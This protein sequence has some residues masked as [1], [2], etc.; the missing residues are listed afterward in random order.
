MNES[1]PLRLKFAE[2]ELDETDARL[3]RHGK[4]IALAPKAFAV[5]CTLARR[6][7]RLVTK[8]ALIDAVW[9]HQFISESVLKT[10]ISEL[11]AALTDD[12][13]APRFIETASRR[14]YRFIADAEPIPPARPHA[15]RTPTLSVGPVP[16]GPTAR[17]T[18]ASSTDA[19]RSSPDVGPL[20]ARAAA[21]AKL[22]DAW[23]E[24]LTAQRRI[25]WISGEAGIG[26]TTLIDSFAAT[27]D[28]FVVALARGQCV[29]QYGAGEPYLP[30]LEALGG[31]CRGDPALV[32]LLRS[33][34]PTWLLQLPWLTEQCERENLRREL[35]GVG[36][37]RMLRE[38]GELFDLYTQQRALLLI[39][40]DLHWSD[41]A[42]V[43][44]IDHVARRRGPARLMWLASF[45][46]AEVIAQEHP[47]KTLRHELRL[48]R[49]CAE[50]ALEPFSEID[51][52]HYVSERYPEARV[53]ETSI[54]A[55]HA[56]TDG[57]PLFV[58]NV[59]DEL[60]AG[61]GLDACGLLSEARI[62]ALEVPENLAGVIEKQIARLR[63][64]E[65]E[66]L[67]VA[68]VC[69]VEFRSATAARALQRPERWAADRCDALVRRQQWL[70]ELGVV[71]QAPPTPRNGDGTL[72]IEPRY[73]F[74]HA[75]YHQVFYQRIGTARRA[76]LHRR[77]AA[78]LEQE[79][80]AGLAVK[81]VERALHF[82]RGHQLVA[83][84]HGYVD[85]VDNAL[86]HFAPHEA[87]N[88]TA[89]ALGL[90]T[91][92]PESVERDALEL[93]LT[94]LRGA[95]AVQL[96]GVSSA[97]AKRVFE[98]SLAL[99]DTIPQHPLRTLV[100]GGLGLTLFNRG[101]LEQANALSERIFEISNHYGDR[102]LF[103]SG[104]LV[105]GQVNIP[106]A[107]Y[108]QSRELLER[109]IKATNELDDEALATAQVVDPRILM[110][111]TLA[112][113]LVQLGFPDQAQVQIDAAR[114]RAQR[115]RQPM[116]KLAIAWFGAMVAV[117]CK[118]PERVA[119]WAAELEE[120]ACGEGLSQGLGPGGWYRGWAEARLGRPQQ[121][122]KIIRQ[123]HQSHLD[124][125]MM[126]GSA[127]VFGYAAEALAL[128]G[129]W[130]EALAELD[131]AFEHAAR[132]GERDYLPELLVLKGR[133]AQAR[134][135][136]RGARAATVAAVAAAREDCA[137][138][139]ALGALA[140]LCELN[141]VAPEDF[142]ALA[143]ARAQLT[144]GIQTELVRRVDV[145]LRDRR[146][147]DA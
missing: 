87:M 113:P 134:G 32:P 115:L 68:S 51:V 56:R 100:L 19:A 48:H 71:G 79:R 137:P 140:A 74:R 75:L 96:D 107:R 114:E 81:A 102:L 11:R 97:E 73:A 47:L 34:A 35:A 84:L 82:E 83:A 124:R 27:V 63:D 25:V 123:A 60:A 15:P 126:V 98:R 116:A 91:H 38:L 30:V 52:A 119:A 36:Q 88:L 59:L 122:Y 14:G 65:T 90:V 144:E 24:T 141:T 6:P 104:C 110:H 93:A 106:R 26:K 120:L 135:D 1:D 55:L 127:E 129:N 105:A 78:C 18:V 42:T 99:L 77:I 22:R 131:R 21:L 8:S 86:R 145:L 95:A 7:Q 128:G 40:E 61:E 17:A 108:Q 146:A 69:G 70:I 132:F 44:L 139:P 138:W 41:Q 45:R 94:A 33:V 54:R 23:A 20:V 50:I 85:A 92:C 5:L 3:A 29:E 133:I 111:A 9:G 143:Q 57:L 80:A 67:E 66:L 28:D 10:T 109:G 117:R 49:L 89:H 147:R 125:G 64:D 13:R 16:H 62:A 12:A 31:L 76:E 39:T 118:D 121:G 53:S 112:L 101:E 46:P 72:A 43:R 2:F 4:P 130:D 136:Q 142:D 103:V 37:D 58:S